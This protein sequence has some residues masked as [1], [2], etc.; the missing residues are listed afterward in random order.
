MVL[1]WHL[2]LKTSQNNSLANHQRGLAEKKLLKHAD[3]D[4]KGA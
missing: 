2:K 4:C 3:L 1:P